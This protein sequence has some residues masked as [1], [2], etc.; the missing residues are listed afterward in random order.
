MSLLND[1]TCVI[2]KDMID[3]NCAFDFD[4]IDSD[5]ELRYRYGDKL[6]IISRHE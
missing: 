5:E 2:K 6:K 4:D 1:G 3:V